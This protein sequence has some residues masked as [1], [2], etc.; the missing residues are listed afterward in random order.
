MKPVYLFFFNSF[1]HILA[2]LG[3]V[4]SVGAEQVA[5]DGLIEPYLIVNVGTGVP[6]ILET[7]R[8][9]RS[10]IVKEGQVLAT[11]QSGVE[12]A[13]MELAKAR[14]EMYATI[15][16]KQEALEFAERSKE[17]NKYLFTQKATSFQQWVQIETQ[18]IMAKHELAQALENRELA[19]LELKRAIEVV[20]RM[21]IRSPVNGVVVERFLSPGEQVEGQP[22]L[23]LAQIDPL[24]VEVI[25]SVDIFDSV[26][27]G[28]RATV[29]PEG[30]ASGVYTAKVIIVDKV[31]DAASGTFG[32]RLELP[33]SDYSLLPGLKCKVIFLE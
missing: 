6:G 20:N 1:I 3:F 5:F 30:L 22:I 21:T 14:A 18:R 31:I 10:D 33:N 11:L 26:K 23:T 2:M 8:V 13:T 7:V 9:D 25:L 19:K 16:V 17:R 24:K 4:F 12:R 15:K 27:V 29:K 28:M 32:V